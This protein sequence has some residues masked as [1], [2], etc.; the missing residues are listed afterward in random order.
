M[1]SVFET[2]AQKFPAIV[3]HLVNIRRKLSTNILTCC[4]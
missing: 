2:K 3:L 4:Q 1:F